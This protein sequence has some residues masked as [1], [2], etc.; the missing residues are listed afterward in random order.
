MLYDRPSDDSL[1]QALLDRDPAL[2]GRIFVAVRSTGIFC[3]LTC[4]ARKPKRENCSF[5][6]SVSTCLQEGFRPCKRCHPLS[7]GGEPDPVI[8]QLVNALQADTSRLWREGDI[9]RMGL[10]PSSV[11]RSFKRRFGMTF[12]EM[13]RISRLRDSFQ[14]L[15]EGDRVIDAQQAAGFDSPSAFRQAF[16]RLLGLK[17]S[18]FTTNA[19]VKADWIDTPLG[20]MIAVSDASHLHLLEFVG[21]KALPTELKA[22]FKA[23]KG[24]LGFGRTAPT[25]SIER[26]LEAYFSGKDAHFSTP[27]AYHGTPFTRSV[28]DALRKIPAGDTCTY[29]ALAASLG[30]PEA[31]RAVARANGANQIAVVVPCHRILGADGSLTG[32]GGG[33]WRKQKLIEL[34]QSYRQV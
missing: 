34:E 28:W 12:L 9:V 10:D 21:R 24:S 7:A 1:Y 17:P 6:E 5:H 19:M 14:A 32:Y 4:P 16:A 8:D 31:V 2:D 15:S 11:R 33:L 18:D 29:G 23:T 20:A 30:K 22:L 26:E 13:A 25:D 3:R 27:L